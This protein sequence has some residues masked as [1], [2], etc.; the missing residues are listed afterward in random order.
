MR[1]YVALLF[2]RGSNSPQ[3]KV[4]SDETECRLCAGDWEAKDWSNFVHLSSHV[5]SST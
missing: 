3:V 5:V 4:F 1:V 2:V